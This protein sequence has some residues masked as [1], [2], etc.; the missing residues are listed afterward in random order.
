[1]AQRVR[2][3]GRAMEELDV[4]LI[5]CLGGLWDGR[6]GLLIGRIYSRIN[7][8]S[9]PILDDLFLWKCKTALWLCLVSCLC[10]TTK[11]LHHIIKCS[12]E[13]QPVFFIFFIFYV[14]SDLRRCFTSGPALSIQSDFASFKEN[15]SVPL[16]MVVFFTS[17]AAAQNRKT[18]CAAVTGWLACG[19]LPRK[20]EAWASQNYLVGCYVL[21]SDAFPL[22][23]PLKYRRAVRIRSMKLDICFVFLFVV[24]MSRL[25]LCNDS[26]SVMTNV[27]I[28]L[29]IC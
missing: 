15:K 27:W 7:F 5:R 18:K 8:S 14:A 24:W 23:V 17:R 10:C 16:Q 20:F 11:K 3:M 29:L 25:V 2:L 6:D 21:C 4:W 19:A 9:Q 26:H 28:L 1:M 12:V 22:F 13:L